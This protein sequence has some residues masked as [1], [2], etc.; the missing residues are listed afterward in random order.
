MSPPPIVPERSGQLSRVLLASSLAVLRSFPAE[1]PPAVYFLVE[2]PRCVFQVLFFA[3]ALEAIGG[4]R[5]MEFGLIGNSA[6]LIATWGL[7]E[8][9]GTISIER[10]SSTLPY[11]VMAPRWQVLTIMAKGSGA[12]IAAWVAALVGLIA[13]SLILGVR[14]SPPAIL[15]V[16]II[17]LLISLSV[18]SF[19][20]LLAA[21]T[22][23]TRVDV[24]VQNLAVY[25]VM[26]LAGVDFKVDAVWPALAGFARLL[27]MTNGLASA[28]TML[29]GGTVS[30]I[31]SLAAMEGAVCLTYL[32][33]AY[34]A[35]R[36][37]LRRARALDR[38][39]TT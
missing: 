36:A 35:L 1:H 18:A 29:A 17:F 9:I 20:L 25:A 26:L 21:L 5:W 3:L 22:I 12:V 27:P 14:I 8:V 33:L 16:A 37:S 38:L 15:Q 30:D 32:A 13:G 39:T 34:V 10:W 24:L 6:Q 7:A 23:G 2:L 28:R 11:I 31:A 19:G 4:R